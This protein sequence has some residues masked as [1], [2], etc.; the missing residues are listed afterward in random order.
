[1]RPGPFEMASLPW[2]LKRWILF[3]PLWLLGLRSFS[4][5]HQFKTSWTLHQREISL[6]SCQEPFLP[7]A[8]ECCWVP[9]FGKHHEVPPS[10]LPPQVPQETCERYQMHWPSSLS[11]SQTATSLTQS[12]A[13]HSTDFQFLPHIYAAPVARATDSG[14]AFC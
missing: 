2:V 9:A 12:A 1:M 13:G 5:V 3:L 14:S 8:Y 11:F 10:T 6:A 4:F 7:S